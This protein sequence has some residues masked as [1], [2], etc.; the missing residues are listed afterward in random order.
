MNSQAADLI[1]S[2]MRAYIYDNEPT[3]PRLPHEAIPS[4]PI[5]IDVLDKLGVQ[6][7][8][9]PTEE[10]WEAGINKLADERDYKSRDAL[11]ISRAGLGDEFEDKL[12][13]FWTEHL[14]EEEEIRYVLEGS[15]YFDVREGNTTDKWIRIAVTAGD[16]L[17]LP[18]GIY[19]RFSV[20]Q[21]G[22]AHLVRLFKD[23]PFWTA[24]YRNEETDASVFNKQYVETYNARLLST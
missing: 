24:L 4:I 8:T 20:G 19:H 21:E 23:K 14:H 16:L 2:N 3:D 13:G 17:I 7:V 15:G 10:D 5:S 18:P 22:K 9:I 6:H 11:D 12:R 1:I